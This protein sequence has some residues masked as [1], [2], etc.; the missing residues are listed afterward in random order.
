MLCC[1]ILLH[2]VLFF[3][4][5]LPSQMQHTLFEFWII[6]PQ[7]AA[8]EMA[9][10]TWIKRRHS[11]TGYYSTTSKILNFKT[12]VWVAHLVAV[13][14]GIRSILAYILLL[15]SKEGNFTA[16]SNT[17]HSSYAP[18]V[19]VLLH[20]KCDERQTQLLLLKMSLYVRSA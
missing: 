18:H 20:N 8:C 2:S 16:L 17:K 1:S 13:N 4:H 19:H 5:S 6:K 7:W 12:L 9:V 14:T 10:N 11:A 3:I 15:P